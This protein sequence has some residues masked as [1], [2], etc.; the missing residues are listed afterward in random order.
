MIIIPKNCPSCGAELIQNGPFLECPNKNCSEVKLH[1]IMKWVNTMDIMFISR[2]TIEKLMEENLLNKIEDLYS[3]TVD[4]VSGIKGFG[5][6]FQRIVDAISKTKSVPIEKFLAGFDMDGL[7]ERIWQPIINKLN[8]SSFEDLFS[9]TIDK[10]TQVPGIAEIRAEAILNNLAELG[11]EMISLSKIVKVD[12]AKTTING[13][14]NGL[15]F[16]FTGKLESLTR[17]EAENLVRTNGGEVK[18]V[19]KDLTYLVTN[20]PNSGTSKNQ[21]AQKL[22]VKIITEKEFEVLI[23]R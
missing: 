5:Q 20:T 2:Q 22:G 3:L 15:S 13:K 11:E 8:I 17:E 10:L 12:F 6:G 16:C 7:G 18:S 23:G 1:R 19:T 14:L 9:L 21:K 4:K